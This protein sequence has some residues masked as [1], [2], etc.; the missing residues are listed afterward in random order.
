MEDPSADVV[1]AQG[2]PP[3]VPVAATV[4][5]LATLLAGAVLLV[6]GHPATAT[7]AAFVLAVL[8]V[9]ASLGQQPRRGGDDHGGTAVRDGRCRGVRAL[10][11]AG[12]R[13]GGG[14][15]GLATVGPGPEVA[16]M[17]GRGRV[18]AELPWLLVL[19]VVVTSVALVIWQHVLDGRPP[20]KNIEAVADRPLALVVL[21]GAA[22]S[23]LNAAVE[24]VIFR[25][26]LQTALQGVGGPVLAILVQAV[27]FGLL[28]VVGVPSGI[29]GAVMAGVW[30]GL[31]GVMRWRTHGLLA[32]YLAH[33]TADVTIFCLLLPS[34]G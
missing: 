12:C 29:V 14:G 28:H 20:P 5:V 27:A 18:T 21:A 24:A 10:A 19:T 8:L 15:L 6:L 32:P 11:V 3:R 7:G 4:T 33:V 25:G 2:T 17:A 22:F 23:L 31:L 26:V 9:V 13:G 1:G 30:G 34:L 16:F